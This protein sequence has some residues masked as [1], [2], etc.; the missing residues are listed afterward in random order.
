[1]SAYELDDEM[2]R[3]FLDGPRP[4]ADETEAALVRALDGQLPL[5]APTKIGA[6]V[7]TND[8]R[9]WVLAPCLS[10]WLSEG[11]AFQDGRDHVG[12]RRF[13]HTSMLGRIVKV[14]SEGVD[15]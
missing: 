5:S 15:L 12:D 3:R 11:D 6:V 9:I 7:Q 2:V 14:L 1:V 4:V 8:G 10:H 13:L